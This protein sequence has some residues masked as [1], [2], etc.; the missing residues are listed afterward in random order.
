MA[1]R[2]GTDGNDCERSAQYCTR[3]RRVPSGVSNLPA[4]AAVGGFFL[5]ST[6]SLK[7]VALCM[8]CMPN[9]KS[10]NRT[11]M[12]LGP[13]R[14]R[15]LFGDRFNALHSLGRRRGYSWRRRGLSVR[16]RKRDACTEV[17]PSCRTFVLKEFTNWRRS[18]NRSRRQSGTGSARRSANAGRGGN[19]LT[20][21]EKP[22]KARIGRDRLRFDLWNH[23]MAKRTGTMNDKA[24]SGALPGGLGIGWARANKSSVA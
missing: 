9:L 17:D 22:R 8:L 19:G 4:P 7:Q 13:R 21:G 3:V 20:S 18:L 16:A 23:R 15:L 1:T 6:I 24:A 10:T 5:L 12:N 14:A 11:W 2:S